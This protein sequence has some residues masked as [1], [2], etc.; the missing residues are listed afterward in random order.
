MS[1]PYNTSEDNSPQLGNQEPANLYPNAPMI[2][3]A[4]TRALMSKEATIKSYPEYEAIRRGIPQTADVSMS[5]MPD[6]SPLIV[7]LPTDRLGITTQNGTPRTESVSISTHWGMSQHHILNGL[8]AELQ[9]GLNLNVSSPIDPE[10]ATQTAQDMYELLRDEVVLHRLPV[11]QLDNTLFLNQIYGIAELIPFKYYL[12]HTEELLAALGGQSLDDFSDE[13]LAERVTQAATRLIVL[14]AKR[15]AS[16]NKCNLVLSTYDAW[17]LQTT[18]YNGDN[19]PDNDA[20]K[21]DTSHLMPSHDHRS[22]STLYYWP[23][24]TLVKY[25]QTPAKIVNAPKISW[26]DIRKNLK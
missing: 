18:G 10:S 17:R 5:H 24:S 1:I 2:S 13:Q 9:L 22:Y 3:S 6:N 23:A 11:P 7:R 14:T 12:K 25:S 4:E 21:I 19:Y 16:L 15:I 26:L 20:V 8:S